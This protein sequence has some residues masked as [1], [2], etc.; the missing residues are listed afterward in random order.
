MPLRWAPMRRVPLSLQITIGMAVG[1]ALGPA[2]GARAAPL[3]ELG[4]LVIQ[5]IKAVATPLL[6]L[7]IV[8]AILKTRVRGRQGAFML[9]FAAGSSC[10]ALAI[11]LVISNVFHPGRLL[12][13]HGLSRP[14]GGALTDKKIE[15]VKTIAGYVPANLLQPFIDNLVLSVVLLAL[16]FGFAARA[17][18]ARD[19]AR[20]TVVEDLVTSLH[21]VSE[22]VLGWVVRLV[23]LAVFGVVAKTVGEYGFAPLKGLGAYLGAG[24]LGMALQIVVVYQLFLAIGARMP[25]RRFWA[26]AREPVAYAMGAG[27][28]LATL[29][30]TL[31]ALDRLGVSRTSSALGACVGT[32]FNNDGIILYEGMA[33]L[34]V[35]QAHGIE[36]GLGQQLVAAGSCLVAAMGGAGVPEA[37]LVSLA[38]VL[39][40]V[41]L[42]LELLPLLLTVDW[43]VGRARSVTNA[44]SD[45]V[46]SI[47]IDRFAPTIESGT[48]EGPA[49]PALASRGETA[50]CALRLLRAS[51]RGR[52]RQGVVRL[53]AEVVARVDAADGARAR[54]HDERR[55]LRPVGEEAHAAQQ[56]A[57]RD[58]R[59]REH[60]VAAREL[61]D[62]ED[63]VDV[64]DAHARRARDLRVVP[65]AQDALHVAVHA[66]QGRG[67]QH[68]LGR[69]A[70]AHEHVDAR[71]G[72]RGRDG[73]AHVAVADEADARARG[74]HLGD[75]RGVARPLEDDGR[76]ILDVDAL[77]ARDRRE[78]LGGAA[79]DVDDARADV[80]A[81]GDLLHVRVGR[82]Q[83]A[84]VLGH[85]DDGQRPRRAARAE[86]R[87]LERVDGDVDG[88]RVG[89]AVAHLFA[90]VEH[91]RLVAL[92]HADDDR[93][94]DVQ[95][96]ERAAH[97]LRR[98]LVGAV[99]IAEPHE[100]SRRERRCLRHTH[101]LERQVSIHQFAMSVRQVGCQ[102][103]YV[104]IVDDS[105]KPI[106]RCCGVRRRRR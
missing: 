26:A 77:L 9:A 22:I 11:G 79:A 64:G 13:L 101:D 37:G 46:L 105:R 44:L 35:A 85:G 65:R 34:F 81:H 60:D 56:E 52:A 67:R 99:M 6:F 95:R 106:S 51:G 28:S 87:A 4:K 30:I 10:I 21:G 55:G 58:A 8:D 72:I 40:T 62:L 3:G 96:A 66:A 84:P 98:G 25:L 39:N 92:A 45:M 59:G 14:T 100:T 27:S 78:V 73:A 70:D 71:V 1:L 15:I 38:L 12:D 104:G 53:V 42:P 86:V 29:P 2:L 20:V 61:V 90:D 57:A 16:L 69:A 75:E 91:G 68:A 48:S 54:A 63:V 82:V 19:V 94:A 102:P 17:L 88:G 103:A 89:R 36:L 5:L 47:M 50:R 97:R 18:R 49:P 31:G 76:E 74:A 33:V 41:G 7:A 32:N 80:R 93:A 83:E 24:L 43:I 23:P